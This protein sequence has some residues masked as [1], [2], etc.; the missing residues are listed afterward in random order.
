MRGTIKEVRLPWGFPLL[1]C[2]STDR[3]RALLA[4]CAG[5]ECP[6]EAGMLVRALEFHPD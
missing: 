5:P 4:L 1:L 3:E 6:G 2:E